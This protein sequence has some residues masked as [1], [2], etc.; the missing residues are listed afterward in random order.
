[1]WKMKKNIAKDF[2]TYIELLTAESIK[3][4]INKHYYTYSAKYLFEP[5][6]EPNPYFVVTTLLFATFK[7]SIS[8]NILNQFE[9]F[10]KG[11]YDVSDYA[12]AFRMHLKDI[13]PENISANEDYLIKNHGWIKEH[14]K[15]KKQ[16]LSLSFENNYNIQKWENIYDGWIKNDIDGFYDS[17]YQIAKY[18]G[19]YW[20]PSAYNCDE[21]GGELFK[22]V[23]PVGR[24][25]KVKVKQEVWGLKRAFTCPVCSIIY[26]PKPGYRYT[27]V[28][29]SNKYLNRIE[30]IEAVRTMG[31]ESTLT[32]RKDI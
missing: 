15:T 9:L 6:F 2:A 30:Y 23:F 12:W 19:P 27:E 22:T 13:L 25:F 26:G 16:L 4:I 31:I 1:M 20:Y 18:L 32:G 5:G 17:H 11:G 10:F 28:K 3:Q 21:C 7:P 24:E 8:S 29:A 14:F